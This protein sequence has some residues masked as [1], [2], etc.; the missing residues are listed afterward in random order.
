MP[1]GERIPVV[2]AKEFLSTRN[3]I[4]CYEYDTSYGNG[5]LC[6]AVDIESKVRVQRMTE[7]D[8][9]SHCRSVKMWADLL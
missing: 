4:A 1:W 8:I 6:R 5:D 2:C 7:M 9:Y 3:L